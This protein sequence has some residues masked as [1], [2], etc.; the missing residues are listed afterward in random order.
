MP[1]HESFARRVLTLHIP[2]LL[3]VLFAVGPYV[4]SFITSISLPG[5]MMVRAG[6]ALRYFPENP[7]FSNYQRLFDRIQF[8]S[9]L[10]DSFVVA[11]LAMLFGLCVSLTASFSFSRFRFWGRRY[12]MLQFLVINMFPIV[13]LLIPLFVIT[14]RL[15]I[16]DTHI[17]LVLAYGTF[18][19]PFSTWM[20]T[21]F[22]N[23]IPKSLDEQA[24]IDGCNRFTAMVRI[25]IPIAM[26][27]IAAT[28]IYIF[29]TSWNE[30]V[31][32][33]VLTGR[34]VETIP[35]ALQRMVG[36]HRIAW[37]LLTA[38]GVISAIPVVVLFFFIQKQLISGMT[39]GA[40][41]A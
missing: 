12:L 13:L 34:N 23:A 2:V 4:W 16:N 27:G 30:F 5:Q 37:E 9:N 8:F 40:V 7:T 17:A 10:T 35:L 19:I 38:G 20:M 1:R 3:I 26:P 31:F 33:S 11:T 15:G 24:Q 32:A 28:G 22:F 21:S 14:S 41:K 18:T 25:I 39:A 6:E 29:I 36:Q